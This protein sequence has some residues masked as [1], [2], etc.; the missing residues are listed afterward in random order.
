ME[1]GC[2]PG[3][4]RS[5]VHGM[6]ASGD[7]PN[8][9]P[10]RAPHPQPPPGRDGPPPSSG[11]GRR[12]GEAGR[13]ADAEPPGSRAPDGARTGTLLDAL[14]V[15]VVMLDTTGRVLLWSP[16]AEEVLG[17]AG[18]HIVGRRVGGLFGPPSPEEGALRSRRGTAPPPEGGRGDGP[19]GGRPPPEGVREPGRDTS[20]DRSPGGTRPPWSSGP[21]ESRDPNPAQQILSEL[22]RGGRWDGI[23]S[24]RHR[25]GHTVQVEARASL[26]VDGDGRPFVLA[27]HGGDQPAAH[28]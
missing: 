20:R 1:A 5:G 14:R 3:P 4:T 23:L 2:A 18:E 8:A 9:S 13:P 16:L 19:D 15:A 12:I 6:S 28:P 27:S 7:D 10:S 11:Q 22:L 25:D 17:W 21:G 24:L 26:L